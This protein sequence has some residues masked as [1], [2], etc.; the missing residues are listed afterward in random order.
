MGVDM[1]KGSFGA[2]VLTEIVEQ[3]VVHYDLSNSDRGAGPDY[4]PSVAARIL[5]IANTYDTMVSEL[6]YRG[7]MTRSEA[8]AELRRCAGTQFDP[9]LVERF[10][11]AVKLRHHE[12]SESQGVVTKE[13]ALGIGLLLEQ[14]ISAL[15]DNDVA[16]LADITASLQITATTHGLDDIAK[17]SKNLHDTL[18]EQHDQIELMQ[19]AG[20]LLD[21]CRS[22]QSTLLNADH[23]AQDSQQPASV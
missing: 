17:L 9:E 16:Q 6:N 22:T 19:M 10:I 13:S 23:S 12:H 20:E 21:L 1:V 14:L 4:R 15:D 2:P 8:F 11:S 18:E 7:K 5:A 3:H